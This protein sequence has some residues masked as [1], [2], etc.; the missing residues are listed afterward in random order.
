M[1]KQ[2]Q[3]ALEDIAL[4]PGVGAAEPIASA[5][6]AQVKPLAM[7][8]LGMDTRKQ[9]GSMN[10]DVIMVIAMNPKSNTATVVSVPRDSNLEMSGYKRQKVNAFYAGFHRTAKSEEDLEGEAADA[11][12]RDKS[13]EMFAE[14]FDIPI[15][16]TAVINFQGFVDVVDKLG[17]IDVYVD[18]DMRYNDSADG[19][20]IDLQ[21]GDQHLDGGEA[22]DFVRYRKSNDGT[23]ASSDFA[24]NDRQ[25]RV[26]AAIVDKMK[27]IGGVSKLP[28]VIGA[29]GDN[30]RTDIPKAQITNMLKAYYDINSSDIRFIPLEGV[31][32][33]PY[34]YLNQDK[35][36]EAKQ[37]LAEELSAEGRSASQQSEPAA[38]ASPSEDE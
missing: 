3:E 14:F 19:T 5:D 36:E 16:Y 18:Q 10:T 31:W 1:W 33:S 27:T 37:A 34:V 29:V 23:A 38:A 9:T 2:A 13:R 15:D 25:S 8:L 35:V 7:L 6:R 28:G 12:A 30:M 4:K 32:K 17:G 11:Y 26:L 24:R 21:K 22:L 20:H